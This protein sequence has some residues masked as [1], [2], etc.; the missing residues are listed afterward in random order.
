MSRPA[1]VPGRA[2]AGLASPCD[3]EGLASP[4]DGEGLS[5]V[6]VLAADAPVTP[7]RSVATAVTV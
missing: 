2:G 5:T 4:C 1:A 3:G 6:M 7:P